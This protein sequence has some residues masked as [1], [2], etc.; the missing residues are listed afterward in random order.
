MNCLLLAFLITNALF[1]GLF[2]HTAHCQVV[3]EFNKLLG[4]K[5]KCPQHTVHLAMGVIFYL[6]S[7]YV[8]QKDSPALK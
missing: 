7:V 1:W 2:P 8:A 3:S 5:V 6:L 4:M